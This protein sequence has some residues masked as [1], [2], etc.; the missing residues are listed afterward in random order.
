MVSWAILEPLGAFEIKSDLLPTIT[1]IALLVL[2]LIRGYH[3][4]LAIS[5]DY[6][7]HTKIKYLARS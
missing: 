3:R 5:Y 4:V 6:Y 1:I 7:L 2:A